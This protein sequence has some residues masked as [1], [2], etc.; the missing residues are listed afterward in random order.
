MSAAKLTEVPA[1]KAINLRG[2]VYRFRELSIREYDDLVKKATTMKPNLMT[3]QEEEDVDSTLLLRFMV[4]K[5]CIQPKLTQSALDELPM[6]VVLKLNQ[7][8]NLMHYG[9][10]PELPVD[11]DE[12]GDS[13]EGEAG[14]N[15]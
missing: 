8:V 9:D 1:E 4:L 7:T 5:A 6:P 10:E 12:E 2:T 13:S 14:G 11:E 3:G 15:G